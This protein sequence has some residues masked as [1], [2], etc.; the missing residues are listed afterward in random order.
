[1]KVKRDIRIATFNIRTI[2]KKSKITELIAYVIATNHDI[3]CL[4]EDML[5]HEVPS[6]KG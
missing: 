4:L 2:K 5:I 6:S 1:M 3:I